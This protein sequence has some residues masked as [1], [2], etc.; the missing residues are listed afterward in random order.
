M[1]QNSSP[2]PFPDPCNHSDYNPLNKFLYV[3]KNPPRVIFWTIHPHKS[4]R[5]KILCVHVLVG[6]C[7]YTSSCV[8]THIWP[9]L[10]VLGLYVDTHELRGM[11]EMLGGRGGLMVTRVWL[12]RRKMFLCSKACKKTQFHSQNGKMASREY[13][14]APQHL[15]NDT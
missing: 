12:E 2:V 3:H 6:T 1:C 10:G 8:S 15:N 14:V 9:M 4:S 7:V 13:F 11:G 5:S